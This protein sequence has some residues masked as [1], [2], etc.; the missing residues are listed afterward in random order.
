MRELAIMLAVAMGETRAAAE[1]RIDAAFPS[2]PAPAPGDVIGRRR[3]VRGGDVTETE[4]L[5]DGS[6]RPKR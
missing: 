5:A 4:L 3:E 1:A 2:D 6:E